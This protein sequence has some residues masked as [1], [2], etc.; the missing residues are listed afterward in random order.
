MKTGI[1]TTS[2][3]IVKPENKIVVCIMNVGLQLHKSECNKQL[4]PIWWKRK[5]P[6]AKYGGFTVMAK[7]RC[8]PNDT[9]DEAMG[10][11]IAESRAKAKAFK[12]AKNVWSCIAKNL[13]EKANIAN[14]MTN[15][16]T[17]METKEKKHVR[18]LIE[19][20]N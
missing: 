2:K 19:Q 15:K 3:F 11:K 6:T 16:Y 5:A 8:N 9:F 18:E 7:A 20:I 17:L 10:K 4:E 1:K 12:I 14:V 13:T